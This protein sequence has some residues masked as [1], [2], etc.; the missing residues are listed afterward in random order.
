MED[1][2]APGQLQLEGPGLQERLDIYWQVTSG[3]LTPDGSWIAAVSFSQDFSIPTR[4]SSFVSRAI[5][6]PEARLMLYTGNSLLACVIYEI[7]EMM[8]CGVTEIADP[9][10]GA[11]KLET[12]HLGQEAYDFVNHP[13]A[14]ALIKTRQNGDVVIYDPISN[15]LAMKT[16]EG[17]PDMMI[18]PAPE[19]HGYPTNLDYFNAFI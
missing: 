18:H 14:T 19:I 6:T 1:K 2:R 13:P 8:E 15:T 11:L 5:H 3:E 12:V 9:S 4:A 10:L 7:L 17:V 16:P